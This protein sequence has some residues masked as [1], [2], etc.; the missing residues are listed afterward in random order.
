MSAPASKQDTT[1]ADGQPIRGYYNR[2]NDDLLIRIPMTAKRVL[3]LG[4][5]AGALGNA[6]K[7]RNPDVEYVGLELDP[8]A[9]EMAK[10]RLDEVYLFNAD[11]DQLPDEVANGAPFDAIIFGDVLEHLYD[12]WQVVSDFAKL[13]SDGGCLMTCIPNVQNWWFMQAVMGRGF[14]YHSE[15]LFDRTH[16]RW[17]SLQNMID[18]FSQAGLRTTDVTPRNFI[19]QRGEHSFEKFAQMMAP[20]LPALGMTPEQF[21]AKAK[22]L[23]FVVRGVKQG[24]PSERML[25]QSIM[26]RPVGGVNDV[27]VGQPLQSAAS[28]PE[29]E[30]HATVRS[31]SLFERP[32][33]QPKVMIWQRPVHHYEAAKSLL[34]IVNKGYIVVTEFDDHTMR[35]EGIE[36][37]EYLTLTGCHGVQT[38]TQVLANIFKDQQP[39]PYQPDIAVFPNAVMQLPERRNFTDNRLRVFFG[40]LN[41]EEDWGPIMP[42]INKALAEAQKAGIQIGFEVI[43]DQGFFDALETKIKRFTPTC[44]YPKYLEIL[45]RCEAALLPLNDNLFN[46]C[47]SDLKFIEAGAAGLAVLASPTVYSA[48]LEHDQTGLLLEQPDEFGASLL[49]LAKDLKEAKRLGDNARAYV[50]RERLSS[51]QIE[52]R[53]SWYRLLWDNRHETTPKLI[54]HLQQVIAKIDAV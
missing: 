2:V 30:V 53:L 52:K 28:L 3:E 31:A 24:K 9:A 7:A 4:C 8:D 39:P 1:T 47:K 38:S 46:Q 44:D 19:L 21:A 17:F 15:G 49:K 16:L 33:E 10:D 11:K 20:S 23:Q 43:H 54:E 40:A 37:H 25:L 12:P 32:A 18:L 34:N 42:G 6:F 13:L 14:E 22:P 36:K 45:G 27:R 48:T 26:L 29:I 41:R 50:S 51:Q 35:W 5:G